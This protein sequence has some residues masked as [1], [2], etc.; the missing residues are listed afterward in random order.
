MFL[1]SDGVSLDINNDSF[2]SSLKLLDSLHS[3]EKS[4]REPWW[5]EN[6]KWSAI[7]D[8]FLFLTC[9]PVKGVMPKCSEALTLRWRSVLP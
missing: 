5:F 7:A 9:F 4:L 2:I 3:I 1:L 8:I 6:K